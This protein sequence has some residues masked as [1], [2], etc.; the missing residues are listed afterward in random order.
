MWVKEFISHNIQ[1]GSFY[2]EFYFDTSMPSIGLQ[3]CYDQDEK[4]KT[5]QTSPFIAG[6]TA[7]KK[8]A[9]DVYGPTLGQ[10]QVGFP[11][12]RVAPLTP[13]QTQA[14]DVQGFLD[15]FAPY[16]DMPMFGEGQAALSGILAGK[17][18]AAPITPEATEQY[19]SG[20]IADPRRKAFER[21]ERP[22][23]REEFAGPG[24]WGSARAKAV[25]E[26]S[27]EMEDWIGEMGAQTRWDVEQANRQIEEAKAGRALAAIEPARAYAGEPTR[28]A[29]ARLA[30]RA[31]VFG[32]SAEQQTQQQRQ[33]NAAIQT[34]AE[35][36]R[37]TD[38]ENLEIL[39]ALLNMQPTGGIT[40]RTSQSPSGFT[41]AANW[42]GVAALGYGAFGGMGGET[43]VNMPADVRAQLYQ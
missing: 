17:T 27:Q 7:F 18:G 20:A 4:T 24:F 12:E 23:I 36:Q 22:A 11:G 1:F 34:F 9:L 21:F 37:I 28:E 10:G 43:G 19:I 38:P 6:E 14:T 2:D 32:L 5:T 41:Q 3:V 25:G 35:E 13:T 26:R 42:A 15:Q 40:T 8:K 29:T 30:G 31:G 16:R 39:M 33:I